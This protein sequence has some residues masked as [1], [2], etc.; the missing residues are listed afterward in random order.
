MQT[1][2]LKDKEYKLKCSAYTPAIY[3]DNFKGRNFLKDYDNIIGLN[4]SEPQISN[5]FRLLWAMIK[6]ATPDV[7]DFEEFS[8]NIDLAEITK[9]VSIVTTTITQSFSATVPKKEEATA[10]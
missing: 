1:I 8:Q 3:E 4:D 7:A 2:L 10:Q 6:E 5:H 9:I